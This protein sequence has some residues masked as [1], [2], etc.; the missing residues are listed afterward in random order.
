MKT[1]LVSMTLSC[2]DGSTYF[3]VLLCWVGPML[4]FGT[5]V[6]CKSALCE[7]ILL[8]IDHNHNPSPFIIA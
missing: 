4:G 1:I 3:E 8:K 7:S 2:F 5:G 6:I